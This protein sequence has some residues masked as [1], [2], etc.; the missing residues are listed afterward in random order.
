VYHSQVTANKTTSIVTFISPDA[1]LSYDRIKLRLEEYRTL[2]AS[3][4]D[5]IEIS[6]EN[7]KSVIYR[8]EANE[9]E[10][11]LDQAEILLRNVVQSRDTSPIVI[12]HHLRDL[13]KV[14]DNLNLYDECRL[15]GDLALDLA[16]ALGR[17]SL[18]FRQEQAVTLALIAE[19]SV[20]Q[21]RA[22]TLFTQAVSV[23][24]EVVE[25]NASHSN[26]TSLL[27]VLDRAGHWALGHSDHGHSDH[28]CTQWLGRAVQLMTEEDPP[29]MVHPDFRSAIYYNYVNGLYG[30]KQYSSALE[31]YC[32]AVSLHRT[33]KLKEPLCKFLLSNYIQAG[34]ILRKSR[35]V[36]WFSHQAIRIARQ[37]FHLIIRFNNFIAAD[38]PTNEQYDEGMDLDE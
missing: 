9:M 8:K 19:L 23:C 14:L 33:P 16:E 35:R 28:L 38:G 5:M 31:A 4:S 12:L 20:F 11:Y 34:D 29:T 2:L 32:E 10:E 25:N 1:S 6:T 26:K 27:I 15:T 22:R 17:R 18:E 36:E 37:A 7:G 21:P 24:E 13:A 30:L 3:D